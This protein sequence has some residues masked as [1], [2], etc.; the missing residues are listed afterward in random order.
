MRI[1]APKEVLTLPCKL[2]PNFLDVYMAKK[3]GC[4][5]TEIDPLE[6]SVADGNKITSRSMC[7]NFSWM[8]NGE[9]FSTVVIL[10]PLGGCEMV[11]GVQWL[12]TLGDIMWNFTSLTMQFQHEGR[13]VALR[14]TTKSPMQCLCVPA[15]SVMS[16]DVTYKPVFG[17]TEEQALSELLKEFEDVFAL[18]TSLPPQRQRDHIIPLKEGVIPVNIRPY[19]HPPGQKDAIETMVQELLDSKVI[20]PSNSPFSSPIVMVKKKDGSW[21]MC[22]DYRQLNKLTIKDKFPIPLIEELIDELHGSKVFSKLDLRAGYHQIRMDEEDIPKTAFR[23]HE[24]HYEFMVMPFGLTN[25]PSTFQ[26]LMNQVFKPFLRKFVLVF[27]DDIL[28]YSTSVEEHLSQLRVI[29][30]TMRE[31]SLYAKQSKCVFGTAQVEYLG[32]VISDQGVATDLAKIAAMEDWPIPTTLK[33]LRGF[34][35]LTG[36]YRRFIKN[37]AVVA[38]P[39]TSLLKK[40]AFQWTEH[41]TQSFQALK[42]AMIKAPVLKLPNFDEPF[43]VETDASGIGI[44]AVLQQGGHHVAYLSK[45]LA[46]KHH[47]LSSYEMEL[48]AVIMTLDRWRGYLLDRHFQIKT[49]HFSLKYFLDQRITTPFQSKWLPKLLG[50]DYEILYKKGKENQVADALSRTSHGGELSSMVVTTIFSGLVEEVQKSYEQDSQMQLLI[51]KVQQG[52]SDSSKY[53]WNVGQ[54]RR[55]GKLV[56]GN[57]ESIRQKLVDYFHSSA[58]GGHSGVFATTKRLNLAAYPGLLQ[59]LPIP[60]QIW[61]DVS[62]DFIDGLPVSNGKTVI[63]VVVDRLSK[64][65]HFVSMA[66]PYTAVQVAGLFLDNIYKLHC[67]PKT[68]VSDRD[69]VFTSLFWKSLF[70]MLKVELHLSSAYHPQTEAVNKTLECYLRCMTGEKPKEWNNWLPLAEFWYNTR[71]HSS[72]KTTPFEI[73]YGQT[74]PQHVTYEAGECRVETVDRTLV[75]RDQAIKLLQFYLKRAQN[76]MKSMADKKRSDREFVEGDWVYLKLQP[77]RQITI[78]QSVQHKLSP[79]FYGPFKVLKK[80]GKVAYQL[81]LPSSAQVHSVFHV[82]QLKKCKIEGVVMGTFPHCQ[83]D[84]LLAATRVAVLD[85]RMV[86]KKNRVAVQ[87]LIQ[88]ANCSK[89]DATWEIYEDIQKR[90]PEFVIDP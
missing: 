72:T 80:I 3:L 22:I 31:N 69:K 56:V 11:L 15:T 53:S 55:K 45:T 19:K 88:W 73:V 83:D 87:L 86:K 71:F 20:R 74:P 46:P 4:K 2:R 8:L 16:L 67:L 21:R 29:L 78:R 7:K 28:I 25:A 58:E 81:E 54:L 38:Q 48:L 64:Y 26:S 60:Q 33:Q 13:H 39:L 49:D 77:Y 47:A 41:A 1:L 42:R 5:I 40:N 44:G 43:V 9:R 35:G 63:M 89:D 10:L 62:M 6:V 23:T 68:I 37:Y 85:R 75:V 51:E 70:K 30:L 17:V 65:A 57:V 52:T 36:Y 24:G 82:S 32:H 59:P 79:K 34:I 61:Q 18:P 12:A 84:G 27:F 14:G 50:Y 90:F 66:H 76:R